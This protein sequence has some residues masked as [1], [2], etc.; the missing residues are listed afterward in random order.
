M[1]NDQNF[2]DQT[3][4]RTQLIEGREASPDEMAQHFAKLNM[5]ER[6]DHL[7]RLQGELKEYSSPREAARYSKYKRALHG[8]HVRLNKVGR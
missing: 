2:I 6:V 4:T 8:M 3:L 7:E 5:A 1:S